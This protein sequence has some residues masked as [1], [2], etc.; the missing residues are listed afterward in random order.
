MLLNDTLFCALSIAGLRMINRLWTT[1][2]RIEPLGVVVR[3]LLSLLVGL[4]V[5]PIAQQQYFL[6]ML[7]YA[8]IVGGW[9]AIR[10]VDQS[11]LRWPGQRFVPAAGIFICMAY[12]AFHLGAAFARPDVIALDKVRYLTTQTSPESTVLAGWSPGVAFRRPAFFYSVLH[13][14]IRYFVPSVAFE[15]L[16]DDWRADRNRPEIIDFD[17]DVR[18]VPGLAAYVAEA[19]APTGV[20]TLWRRKP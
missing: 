14:E 15:H 20:S 1:D 6:L 16:I 17:D 7:P 3:P 5:M 10:L 2:D 18:A 19:Y 11:A 12:A 9:M 4:L 8:A 13:N